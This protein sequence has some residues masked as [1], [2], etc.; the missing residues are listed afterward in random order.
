[1]TTLRISRARIYGQMQSIRQ[2]LFGRCVGL[3]AGLRQSYHCVARPLLCSTPSSYL[4]VGDK[5]RNFSVTQALQETLVGEIEVAQAEDNEYRESPELKGLLEMIPFDIKDDD[6]VCFTLERTYGT[7][8]EIIVEVNV[9]E[10]DPSSQ[11]ELDDGEGNKLSDQI[12][13]L[14]EADEENDFNA[15]YFTTTIKRQGTK[16]IFSC[17]TDTE[18]VLIESV[19]FAKV[20]DSADTGY[21]GPNFEELEDELQESL[22]NYLVERGVGEELG[23]FITAYTA[24]K[25][26]SQYLTWLKN[27]QTFVQ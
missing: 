4:N 19:R 1:L 14:R 17:L 21:A 5:S 12:E 26:N 25:E 22:Y 3:R 7:D 18:G 23:S 8:E 10:T 24:L 20:G 16:M 9:E 2:V 15:V 13:E 6:G 11:D 27:M